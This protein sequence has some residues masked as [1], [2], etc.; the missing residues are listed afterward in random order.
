MRMIRQWPVRILGVK[1][2]FCW[3]KLSAMP[4]TV[5]VLTVHKPFLLTGDYKTV[6]MKSSTTN[7]KELMFG[8]QFTF[9][10]ILQMNSFALFHSSF[11]FFF[12]P[13]CPNELSFKWTLVQ[14]NSRS[15]HHWHASLDFLFLKQTQRQPITLRWTL[16]M[17]SSNELFKF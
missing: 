4:A 5:L 17:N 6:R 7:S 11:L 3:E 16:Q 15:S 12:L 10:W 9:K 8:L 14:M 1:T 2:L 13:V